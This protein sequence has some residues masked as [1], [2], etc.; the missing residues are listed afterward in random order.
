MKITIWGNQ[1]PLRLDTK[2]LHLSFPGIET[3]ERGKEKDTDLDY[4]TFHIGGHFFSIRFDYTEF[5]LKVFPEVYDSELQF[6]FDNFDKAERFGLFLRN[7]EIVEANSYWKDEEMVIYK[8]KLDKL[9]ELT[10][11]A[12][13]YDYY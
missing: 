4:I 10:E 1:Y 5:G 11:E 3:M 7:G 2:D 6:L 8:S 9:I 13:L 12:G